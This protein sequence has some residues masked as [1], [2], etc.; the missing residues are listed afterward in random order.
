MIG[1]RVANA[2]VVVLVGDL[3][4]DDCDVALVAFRGDEGGAQANVDRPRSGFDDDERR[5]DR[6]FGQ[7]SQCPDACFEV[8]DDDGVGFG[9]G[10]EQLLSGESASRSIRFGIVDSIDHRQANPIGGIGPVC[11]E[12]SIP[13]VRVFLFAFVDL[14]P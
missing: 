12:D 3:V 5:L 10:A 14:V 11:L 13:G 4:R 1:K 2:S 7:S 8:G 9:Y 6:C